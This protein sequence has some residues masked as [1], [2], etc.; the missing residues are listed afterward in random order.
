MKILKIK[1][2]NSLNETIRDI[3]FKEVGVSFIYGDIQEPKN[4]GAT[5]NSLGKTLLL[6]CID[7]IYGANEDSKVIKS[8]I[9]GYVLEAIVKH[10]NV[11]FV[12]RRT[13][14]NSEEIYLN[15][16]PYSLTD[17]RQFFGIKRS[18]YGKQIIVTKKANEISYRSNPD[19]EDVINLLD[20][21]GLNDII[22][23]VNNIYCTQDKIKAYKKNKEDL[24]A[25]YGDFDLKEI[26]E[27]I[28]FIDKEVKRLTHELDIISQ[29]IKSIEVSGMQ[30]NVVEEYAMKSSRLKKTKS[31]YEKLKLECIRLTEFI[32]S[33]NKIDISSEHILAL[34]EKVKQ[35]IPELAKRKIQEVEAFHQKVFDE[36]KDFL[37]SKKETIEKE[38]SKLETAIAILSDEVDKLGKLI[39]INQV[40]QESIELYGKYNNDLQ[41]LKYKEGKLSQVK[42][43]DDNIASEDSNLTINFDTANQ[44]LKQYSNLIKEYRDFIYSITKSIYDE[45]VYSYFDIKVRGKHQT[46][47]PVSIEINLKGDTGEGVNEVKKNLIDYLLFKYNLYMDFL[48]QDSACYNGIDPRQVS[49]MI[50]EVNRI[51]E[52]TN[53]QAIISINKYQVGEYEEVINFIKAESAVI[54]SEKNKLLKFDFD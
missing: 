49:S 27:E 28:Y 44:V 48:I 10:K 30:I 32:D 26:D 1:I 15:N 34:Y 39:S 11:K 14:G 7:Y 3:E 21:L 38:L 41:E 20:L 54:L 51:S 46:R 31:E 45:D 9:H 22:K 25:F 16:V 23:S 13:L 53:K 35:E 37:S 6:K 43:I 5:I 4:L 8:V 36:R 40:Y 12:V 50:T 19:K 29:K 24:V 42:K 2:N 18:M 52:M 47:R 33:S 17:Y